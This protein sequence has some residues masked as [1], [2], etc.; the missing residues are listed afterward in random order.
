MLNSNKERELVYVVII[1]GIEP[2]PGYDKV[3]AAIV[4]GWHVI[5]QKG[6]FKVGDPAIYF[7]IDS[8]VPADRE[9]FA[10]LEKRHYKVKRKSGR[11]FK[12]QRNKYANKGRD[13]LR[14]AY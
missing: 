11:C 7:E 14:C 5:V 13:G 12:Q 6:Q 2:I 4:G 3:E 1:D 9:C 8:R 10:F